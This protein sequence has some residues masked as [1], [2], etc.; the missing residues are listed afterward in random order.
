MLCLNEALCKLNFRKNQVLFCGKSVVLSLYFHV[1]GVKIKTQ[2]E[3]GKETTVTSCKTGAADSGSVIQHYHFTHM[4][5]RVGWQ[6][7]N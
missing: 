2:V 5:N 4:G 7:K 6:C 1:S 3:I